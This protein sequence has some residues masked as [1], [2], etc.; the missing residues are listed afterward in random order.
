MFKNLATKSLRSPL[1]ALSAMLFAVGTLGD[2]VTT[3]VGISH[4]G[5]AES[6]PFVANAIAQYGLLEGVLLTKLFAVVVLALLI[7][8]SKGYRTR[9]AATSFIRGQGE[10]PES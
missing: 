9:V 3:H 10:Y 6:T 1:L 2:V 4:M 8:L 7:A 5:L